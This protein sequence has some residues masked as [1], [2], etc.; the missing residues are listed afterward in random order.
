MKLNAKQVSAFGCGREWRVISAG[1]NRIAAERRPIRMREINV[2]TRRDVAQQ[3][4]ARLNRDLIPTHMGRLHLV[5]ES[6]T[7]SR[8]DSRPPQII[9]LVTSFE[10]PL[11]SQAD[12]EHRFL[13]GDSA[14]YSGSQ[15]AVAQRQRCSEIAYARE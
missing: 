7:S 8:E 11:Q 2:G 6:G 13:A 4:R 5:G 15:I 14:L 9:S 12:S 10:H 3:S 1:G